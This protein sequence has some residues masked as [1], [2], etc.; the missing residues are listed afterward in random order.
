[1][2]ENENKLTSERARELQRLGS[3][4]QAKAKHENKLIRDEILKRMKA[5]DWSEI[6][7]GI[8]ARAKEDT[9]SA[10]FLRDTLGQKPADKM[11]IEQADVTIDFSDLPQGD[12]TNEN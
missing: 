12:N 9:K 8:I 4:K 3:K 1:M 10:E 7:D 6:A 5:K 11:K 2:A